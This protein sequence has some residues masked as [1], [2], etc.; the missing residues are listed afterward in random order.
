MFT[1]ELFIVEAPQFG[2]LTPMEPPVAGDRLFV[3]VITRWS[4]GMTCRVGF[5]RPSGVMKQNRSR[6]AKSTTCWYEKRTASTPS[7]LKSDGGLLTTL[8]AAGRGQGFGTGATG[9]TPLDCAAL[10][11]GWNARTASV[12]RTISEKRC[13]VVLLFL[14]LRYSFGTLK[15]RRIPRGDLRLLVTHITTKIVKECNTHYSGYL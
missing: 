10:Q 5:C 11:T 15:A 4:P 13:T 6:P 12:V 8:P 14:W 1:D 3:T 9:W 7:E 2:A